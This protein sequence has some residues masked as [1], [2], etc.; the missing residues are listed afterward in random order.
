MSE[1]LYDLS[2]VQ[3]VYTEFDGWETT[4]N[5]VETFLDLPKNAQIYINFLH[6]ELGV[7]IQIIS[8]GPKR[9]QIIFNND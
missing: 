4:I 9:N 2:N 8:I 6:E 7:P 1:V 5:T 3:P